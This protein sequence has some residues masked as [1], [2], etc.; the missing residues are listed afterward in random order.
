MQRKILVSLTGVNRTTPHVTLQSLLQVL[1]INSELD[2]INTQTD[3]DRREF[4]AQQRARTLNQRPDFGFEIYRDE[5]SNSKHKYFLWCLTNVG[6]FLDYLSLIFP[7]RY[8]NRSC[9][10]CAEDNETASHLLFDCRV[11]AEQ[12]TGELEV[13]C[14]TLV[15]KLY[16]D[17]QHYL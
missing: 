2:M 7:E 6:P 8:P 10:Y 16:K 1:D 14:I 11:I 13:K 3:L 5:I 9:R 12:S 15:K 17:H 4:R